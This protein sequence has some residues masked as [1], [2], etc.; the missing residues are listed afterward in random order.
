MRAPAWLARLRSRSA[1]T[2]MSFLQHLDELRSVLISLATVLVVLAVGAWFVSGH[3]LDF[4]VGHTVG[5]AQ[6]I[7]PLE[8]FGARIKLA[9]L[10]AVIAGL[11]FFAYRVWGFI[12]P[13]LLRSE[14]R[15]VL[16]LVL[17]STLLF[18]LGVGFSAA[19][20]SPTMLK[21][22]LS[23]G[24]ELIKADIA[25][26]PLLDFFVKMA[27]ACGLLF[28]VPVVIAVLS[29]FGIVTP[30]LLTSKWRH[31]IVIILIIAAVV[32]PG[33]GPSQVVLA[34]PVILLYFVSIYV[35]KM[36]WRGKREAD[37]EDEPPEDGEA[38]PESEMGPVQEG[39][40][41]EGEARRSADAPGDEGQTPIAGEGQAGDRPGE[42]DTGEA[43][44]DDDDAASE[45][46][47][48]RPARA[49]HPP[50]HD[51]SI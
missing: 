45:S 35:S 31:A 4:L 48:E 33:D 15:I 20:L 19:L 3:V 39:G 42:A 1:T 36:I 17:W 44:S 30:E 41:D 12:V 22:M 49:L 7:K 26:A 23:F 5:T 13:G 16:P 8:A 32:T 14:K 28:Q 21:I 38:R 9:L 29:H 2:E 25:V 46:A 51:Y 10:M 47:A 27:I 50:D 24:T 6:F 40:H 18:L 34:I 37:G 43:R 11:P